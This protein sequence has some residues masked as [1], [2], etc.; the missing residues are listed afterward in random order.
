MVV[1]CFEA[2]V[3]VK[4]GQIRFVTQRRRLRG[5][6]LVLEALEL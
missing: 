6:R 2:D 3:H 5:R 4:A 1:V